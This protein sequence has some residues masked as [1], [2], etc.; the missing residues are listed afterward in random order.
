MTARL[1]IHLLTIREVGSTSLRFALGYTERKRWGACSTGGM[2]LL[3]WALRP[4]FPFQPFLPTPL[5]TLFAAG[6]VQAG[7]EARQKKV[8][9]CG[10]A[11]TWKM[12][13]L[14]RSILSPVF[15]LFCPL[16]RRPE[17]GIHREYLGLRREVACSMG[18]E[19]KNSCFP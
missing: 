12:R 16:R 4:T 9:D 15:S 1:A 10:T 7:G 19:A 14:T 3:L 2:R 6:V 11:S 17:G 13:K 5:L 18:K 8:H